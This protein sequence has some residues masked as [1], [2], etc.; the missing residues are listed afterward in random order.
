M[1]TVHCSSLFTSVPLCSFSTVAGYRRAAA[2]V[3]LVLL[4][5]LLCA[6]VN[7]GVGVG[8]TIL[9]VFDTLPPSS[10]VAP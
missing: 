4:L 1:V 9:V 3:A 8:V 2:V 10:R 5:L 6:T 7:V